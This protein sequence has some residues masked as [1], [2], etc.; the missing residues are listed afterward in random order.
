[1]EGASVAG[2]VVEGAKKALEAGCDA[3]LIC[4]RPDMADQL[5]NKLTINQKLFSISRQRLNRLF[6]IDAALGWREMQMQS[7]YS[8]AKILLQTLGLVA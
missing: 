1:M 6:P 8:D 7:Q 4:N 3:V 2:N 5:L